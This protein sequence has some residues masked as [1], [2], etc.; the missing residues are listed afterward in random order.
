MQNKRGRLSSI[1]TDLALNTGI[2][3]GGRGHGPV[4]R[5]ILTLVVYYR[6]KFSA[7]RSERLLPNPI[8]QRVWMVFEP[9]SLVIPF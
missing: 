5:M 2:H 7:L 9:T 4:F 3:S 8:F 6:A 1:D